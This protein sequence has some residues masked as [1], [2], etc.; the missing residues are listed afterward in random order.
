M[1]G[2]INMWNPFKQKSWLRFYSLEPAVADLY[3]IVPTSSLKRKWMESEVKKSKCPFSGSQSSSNCPGIKQ[4]SRMGWVVTAP[5]DFVIT[6]NGD[7]ETFEW[8]TQ[9]L[10]HDN[11][12]YISD[13]G[14]TQAIPLLDSPR[15][16]LKTII[17]V[18][19]PWRVRASDDIVLIQTPVHW[20]NEHRFT[21]ASGILD[22][23]YALQVNV[24][25]IWHVMEGE[26]CIKAGTPLV[27]Y[28]PIPRK[29][30]ERS[31]Y[32]MTV[33]SA[34]ETEYALEKAFRYSNSS[35]ILKYDSLQERIQRALK[36][37][38]RYSNGKNL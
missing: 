16:T 8:K 21:V 2:L 18:E 26:T 13:H 10:F 19:T 28:T 22:C 1:V 25:L 5:A 35:N 38:S 36:V 34:G 17:K 27:Q 30:L 7:G 20:M 6:T 15:D 32:N 9:Y 29:Y 33:D 12:A 23:R 3:P 24:Q 11:T 14:P 37:I 31:W 4:F